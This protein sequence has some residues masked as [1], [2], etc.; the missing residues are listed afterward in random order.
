MAEGA[1]KATGADY[2]LGVTGIAGPGG[3]SEAKP[4]GTVYISLAGPFPTVVEKF[5]NPFDRGTFKQ[6]TAQN[7]LDLLR[8]KLL[9]RT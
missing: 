6:V 2:A 8:Q 1:R 4:V 5:F 7:A 9:P 3:G